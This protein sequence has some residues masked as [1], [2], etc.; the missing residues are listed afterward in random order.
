MPYQ[1]NRTNRSI[2]LFALI[3]LLAI[4]LLWLSMV[5]ASALHIDVGSWGDQATLTGIN[6]PEESSTE[7][8]RWTTARAVLTLPNL[9]ASYRLLVI[10]AHGWRPTGPY[11]RI[12]LDLA[13]RPWGQIQ[14][15]LPLR[16][17]RVLLPEDA[18]TPAV[19]VGLAS[20]SY[21]PPG[22]PRTIGVAIDWFELR[23]V[24]SPAFPAF[25][26]LLG[27]L[28]LLALVFGMI[29]YFT[30]SPII[31]AAI[32]TLSLLALNFS[33]PLWLGLA[34]VPWL[35][36]AVGLL[37]LLVIG[38]PH[39]ERILQ[40]WMLP[41]QA[42]IAVALV[43][44]ALAL[45]IA[46]AIHPFFDA[47]DLP[48]HD[49]WMH[50]V[51]AGQ[52]YLYSTP[53]ELQNRLTFNPPASYLL[54]APIWLLL[55][56]LRLSIQAGTALIDGLGCLFLLGVAR[57]LRLNGRSALLGL[58]L[59]AALPINLTMLWWGFVAND[60]A[61]SAWILLLW[62]LL[63]QAHT[64][65]RRTAL[66][67]GIIAAIGVTTHI[68]ALVLV[69]AILALLLPISS[70]V[71][72]RPAWMALWVAFGVAAAATVLFYF[73]AAIEPILAQPPNPNARTLAESFARG[74]QMRDLRLVFVGR[75]FTLGYTELLLA[76]VP[77]GLLIL[78]Q[79]QQ[80]HALQR[81]LLAIWVLI[82]LLFGAIAIS[83]GYLT[84][85]IYFAA[86]LFCLAGGVAL[87]WI[88]KRPGGR[89]VV[90]ALVLAVAWVGA[91]LWFSGVLLR[92][93]P[94]L[95]PLTQ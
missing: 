27:Q 46:G 47:H 52:L 66:V 80:R 59:Y 24:G 83:L 23:P 34:I 69:V 39:L 48:V 51:A 11:P 29:G 93:K 16:V 41:S 1:S 13:G 6:G 53:A 20:E 63:C 22:D 38:G 87:E 71:L 82:S 61:Q 75:A 45:R 77:S 89:I 5:R 2:I 15:T 30:R 37:L 72:P 95:V 42:R 3:W 58:A 35:I 14:T 67:V 4:P 90:I 84:R 86:P 12:Q 65:T 18:M 25:W 62:L 55:G 91:E 81:S 94:S 57:E 32:A 70:V 33:E 26:Q 49:R 78:W 88:W 7:T 76:L 17:Y 36:L 10:R 60:I 73:S 28:L 92:E 8:Y 9:S 54:L 19:R 79:A 56:D 40:P 74:M 85:Y 44:A 31:P 68:G 50:A 64:P 21:S 43:V